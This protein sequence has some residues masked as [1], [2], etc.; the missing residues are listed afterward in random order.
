MAGITGSG[1]IGGRSEEG[2]PE[3][4]APPGTDTAREARDL[5]ARASPPFLFNHSARCYAWSCALG[6]LW[7]VDFDRE[8]LYTA[9]LLHDL[10]LTEMFD[11]PGCFDDE[12][13]EAARVFARE[14]GWS[15]QRSG[16]LASVIRL[17][18]AL[19]VSP[20][21]ASEAYLLEAATGCDVLGRF[22]DEIKKEVRRMVLTRLP[23]IGFRRPF[24][25][26]CVRR[27]RASR[28]AW[29]PDTSGWVRGAD[30]GFSLRGVARGPRPDA[31]V[32]FKVSTREGAAAGGE[33]RHRT[34]GSPE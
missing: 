30:L 22:L 27:W 3:W 11:G 16:L 29:W 15:E 9:C 31:H 33:G 17:H 4:L 14:R 10:G 23:R 28:N 13:A 6:E 5:C 25:R 21:A 8:L 2:W 34:H 7:E 18:M 20:S 24:W 19:E 12:G 1:G 26:Y 32:S